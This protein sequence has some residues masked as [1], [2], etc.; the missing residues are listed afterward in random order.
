MKA[1]TPAASTTCSFV[2]SDLRSVAT[3]TPLAPALAG[4]GNHGGTLPPESAKHAEVRFAGLFQVV[5]ELLRPGGVPQFRQ[6]LRLDLP[7]SLAR[8]P[9]LL[10]DLFEGAR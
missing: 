5:A 7:D 1:S 8:D 10:A 4:Q 9:E 2:S 6:R 3:L